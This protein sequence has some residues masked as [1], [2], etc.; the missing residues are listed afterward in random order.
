MRPNVKESF[1][2]YVYHKL[3]TVISRYSKIII[4]QKYTFVYFHGGGGHRCTL[5]EREAEGLDELTGITR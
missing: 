1:A 3:N 5:S 4:A 2:L